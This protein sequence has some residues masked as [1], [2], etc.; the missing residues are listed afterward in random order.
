LRFIRCR[1]SVWHSAAGDL[2]GELVVGGIHGLGGFPEA[3]GQ[4]K[5]FYDR[6]AGKTARLIEYK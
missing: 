6:M 2:P 1:W 4:M 3:M 5:F